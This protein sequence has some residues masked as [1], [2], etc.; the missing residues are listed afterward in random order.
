MNNIYVVFDFLLST[1]PPPPPPK[2]DNIIVTR[3]FV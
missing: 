1:L 2:E 3:D